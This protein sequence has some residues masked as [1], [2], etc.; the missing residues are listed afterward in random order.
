MGKVFVYLY[1]GKNGLVFHVL[2]TPTEDEHRKLFIL[3]QVTPCSPCGTILFGTK[4][5]CSKRMRR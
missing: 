5:N 2:S 1:K 4:P 3:F